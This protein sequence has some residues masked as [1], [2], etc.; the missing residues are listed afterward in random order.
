MK[1][2]LWTLT[3][4]V[5][6]PLALAAC[7]GEE[8]AAP[9]TPAPAP[10]APAPVIQATPTAAVAPTLPPAAATGAPR[11][12]GTLKVT[13]QASVKSLDPGF[14]P[15]YVTTA[16]STHIFDQLLDWDSNKTPKPQMVS[17]WKVSTDGK[18]YTFTLR[19]GLTFHD[20]TPVTTDDVLASLAR[21]WNKQAAGKLLKEHMEEGGAVRDD[22]R[23]FTLKFKQPYGAVID[24]LGY[25]HRY[26]AIYKKEAAAIPGTEDIGEKN[27]IGS[28][29]YKLAKWEVGNRIILERHE[30]YVPRSEPGDFL[31]GGQVAYL[32][33]I[34]WLEIPN[35]ETKIAG[36]KTGQFDVVDGAALDFFK[37]LSSNPDIS[38]AKYPFHQSVLTF[39][40]A[41]PPT[42]NPKVRQAILAAIDPEAFMSSLGDKELWMLCPAV[43]FCGSPNES[44]ARAELYNQK[45][46]QKAIDMLKEAGAYGSTIRVMNPTD[47]ATI[48][49]LGQVLKPML[50]GIGFKVEMP[51][52]D[53]A[54]LVSKLNATD[55][56]IFTTWWAHWATPDP[57]TDVMVAGTSGYGGN[58]K[59]ER[60]LQARL[61]YA[62]AT[63]PVERQKIVDEI[64]T[65]YYEDLPKIWLGQFSTIFPHRKWVKNFSVP[66]IPT[67]INVWLEK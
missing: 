32:D 40:V 56:N 17:G 47:Y 12:G 10:A 62:T 11:R 16:T 42:D 28:G 24:N 23:T 63:D 25:P 15:A 57:I 3:V 48:A 60:M 13:S 35:E 29:P 39:Q 34:E 36:L 22:D 64:Q 44:K 19:E 7:R 37:D 33:S 51:A 9:A 1:R 65:I 50:E 18:A 67:Y 61:R 14:A 6:L 41:V 21:W 2:L 54:T 59:S 55:Y 66:A 58:Y 45:N 27:L 5:T 20:G 30:A 53:W 4:L 49:P 31:A 46:P 43:F 8:T 38:V 52:M 26:T